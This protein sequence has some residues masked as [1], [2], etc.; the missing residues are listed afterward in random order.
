M[1]TLAK[2]TFST[3]ILLSL[4]AGSVFFDYD[5]RKWFFTAL[6][7][8]LGFGASWE[9][10]GMLNGPKKFNGLKWF[11]S[12]ALVV[13]VFFPTFQNRYMPF[14]PGISFDLVLFAFLFWMIVLSTNKNQEALRAAINGFAV[15]LLF[16]LAL[17]LISGIYYTYNFY[18]NYP[19]TFLLFILVTKGGDI[20]AYLT[21]SLCNAIPHGKNH[22]LV[23]SI[24][25]AKSWEGLVGGLVFSV[26]ITLA[27]YTIFSNQR[28]GYEWWDGYGYFKMTVIGVLLFFGGM[29][30]DLAESSLKRTCEVKDSGHFLPGIGG[31]FD[32]VDSLI[33]NSFVFYFILFFL[34][35]Q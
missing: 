3:I 34:H 25:P 5:I 4:L 33:I 12:L 21:G 31:L 7:A 15:F 9:C 10:L 24:S 18:G 32:L 35:A 6:C 26:A 2:R 29:V 22:K 30:G 8:L 13:V 20:G 28:N 19:A 23:P 16:S 14:W 1:S 27:I 11:I 17:K